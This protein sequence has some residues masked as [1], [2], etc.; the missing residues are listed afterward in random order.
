MG[1]FCCRTRRPFNTQWLDR[2]VQRLSAA[3]DEGARVRGAA[4]G[5]SGL[6]GMLRL[7]GKVWVICAPSVMVL[8]HAVGAH[9]TF[10]ASDHGWVVSS[11]R[12][13]DVGRGR[14]VGGESASSWT[15]RQVAAMEAVWDKVYGTR[16]TELVV[17]GFGV[18]GME[19]V[20][21]PALEECLEEEGG[22][23]MA[24]LAEEWPLCVQRMRVCTSVAVL[25]APTS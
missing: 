15:G 14:G 11:K 25:F 18:E 6:Q 13:V 19:R 21:R 16:R 23:R 3:A 12:G 20:L 24:G 17:I 5:Q 1:S 4:G 22:G 2:L 10:A 7:K 9:H 8:W